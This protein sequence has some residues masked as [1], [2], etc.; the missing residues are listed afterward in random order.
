MTDHRHNIPNYEQGQECDNY[1][2]PD[3][4]PK[5]FSFQFGLPAFQLILQ[6]DM[7]V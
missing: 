7:G 1:D 3:L 5:F 6:V 4:F 2:S